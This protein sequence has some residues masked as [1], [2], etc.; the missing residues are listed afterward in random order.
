ME[1]LTRFPEEIQIDASTGNPYIVNYE[2]QAALKDTFQSNWNSLLAALRETGRFLRVRDMDHSTGPHNFKCILPLTAGGPGL[3]LCVSMTGKYLGLY[4]DITGL[5]TDH[6]PKIYNYRLSRWESHL[7]YYPASIEQETTARLVLHSCLDFFA[8]FRIVDGLLA[9][10]P[11][12]NI[13]IG[14]TEFPRLDV[15]QTIFCT[16]VHGML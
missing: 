3:I 4:Y 11:I 6:R 5:Q 15:F 2:E 12:E 8:D 7:S 16:N 1:T 13:G 14:R 10:T 9:G